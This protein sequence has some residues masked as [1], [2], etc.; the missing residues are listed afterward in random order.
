MSVEL[1]TYTDGELASLSLAGRQAAFAEIMERHRAA[2]FR[3]IHGMV[4]NKEEA[5]DLT[6]D[7]FVSAFNH[8]FKYDHDRPLRAWLSRIA[9]NKSRDFRRRQRVRQLFFLSGAIS[10]EE[11]EAVPD[12]SPSAHDHAGSRLEMI[13]LNA[14]LRQ[15]SPT[16]REVLILRTIE[17]MS[18]AE[19][20]EMLNIS[21]K[22]VET[23]LYRARQRLTEILSRS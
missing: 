12:D 1:K 21:I 16:L 3:L 6:Q 4:G 20:A 23:R 14:A 9:I 5:L 19:T 15:L 7:T 13:R 10:E 22:A 17:G 2:I 18:Q 11:L 8:L